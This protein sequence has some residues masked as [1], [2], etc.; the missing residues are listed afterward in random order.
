MRGLTNSFTDYEAE[1]CILSA[2]MFSDRACIEV[3][4]SIKDTDFADHLNAQ[5][6]QVLCGLFRGGV[7][8]TFAELLKEGRRMGLFEGLQGINQAQAIAEAFIDEDNVGYWIN[9]VK[10]AKKA[11]DTQSLLRRCVAQMKDGV[12]IRQ[13]IVEASGEFFTLAMDD[14]TERIDTPQDVADLGVKLLEERTE[15]YRKLS[16]ECRLLG[17][18]PLEGVPTGLH[19]LDRMTLGLKPGDLAILGA[20]TGH[21]KTAF[22][23]NVA[24]AACVDNTNNILYINTE[25]SRKQI[26]RRWGAILSDVALSQIQAGSVTN[27]QKETV[28]EAYNRLRKSGFYP[29]SI[30]NLTP[31]KLDVLAR[32]AKIQ[33]DVKLLILDYVGRM[34]KIQPDMAEWQVLEQIIKSQKILAQ[35]LDIACLVLV[36]LNPDGTLQ[37]AKRMENECDL[38]LKLL[39][40]DAEGQAKVEQARGKHFED[41]NYRIFINKARDTESGVSIPLIFDK[42]K[43]QIREA[44][45]VQTGWENVGTAVGGYSQWN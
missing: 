42:A 31:Q 15:K 21:G 37:G 5:V 35:T 9:K 19:T 27:E 8:P 14:D 17:Q 38:M 1:R 7:K 20:Q 26:A 28:I 41:F 12:D 45:E 43:Q 10:E 32:K 33:Y 39:P 30:P 36:Q 24:K 3:M 44:Q 13:L 6:Y 18:V 4:D 34:E 25:M 23:L 2:M 29:A 16:E 40:V 22:A 11:R